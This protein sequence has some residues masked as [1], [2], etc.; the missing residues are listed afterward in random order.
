MRAPVGTQVEVTFRNEG[1]SSAQTTNLT[2]VADD[3]ETLSRANFAA[4]ADVSTVVS[5]E[6]LS[7]GYGH[8]NAT[9][10]PSDQSAYDDFKAAI[11]YFVDAD[12][13]GLILDIR[14]NRGGNDGMAAAWS[15]F[16]YESTTFYEYQ[17]F[18]NTLTGQFALGVEDANGAVTPG[19]SSMIMPQAPFFGK[20]VVALVNPG[21]I[22]SGEGVAMGIGRAPLGQVLGFYG[23]NGSFGMVGDGVLMPLSIEIGFPYGRSLDET[24]TIQLDSKNGRG[25]VAPTIRVPLTKEAAIAFANGEDPELSYA[26]AWLEANL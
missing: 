5:C 8:L 2:A 23:T 3:H 16:F 17:E 12:V 13:P 15:G 6:I 11:Q 19:G 24:R 26:I 21:T 4:A 18:Y 22:S 9:Y 1:G 14:G 10:E 20:K 7:S 25:G